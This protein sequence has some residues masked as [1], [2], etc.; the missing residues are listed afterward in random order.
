MPSSFALVVTITIAV[1]CAAANPHIYATA[2]NLC[3][4]G[5]VCSSS[6]TCVSN[7]RHTGHK[8]ACSPFTNAVLCGDRRFSCPESYIC[9]FANHSCDSSQGKVALA[10]NED[11]GAVAGTLKRT[12]NDGLCDYLA[13]Y[14]PSFCQCNQSP[15]G[16]VA[17]INCS[18]ISGF[19]PS[20]DRAP[21]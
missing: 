13:E 4:N 9:N 21:Q 20:F 6:Q 5:A 10:L 2:K 19:S 11:G 14:T 1:A 16:T 8:Y 18:V 12:Q 7:T 15:A 3:G 17:Q